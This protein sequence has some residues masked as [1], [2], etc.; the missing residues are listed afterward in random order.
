MP[1]TRVFTGLMEEATALVEEAVNKLLE[2]QG[3]KK[4][5]MKGRWGVNAA[6][7]NC[8]KGGRECVGWH[9][10]QLTY[11][12]PM[13]VIASLSLGCAREF[14]VRRV[15]G[16]EGWEG[17]EKVGG[18]GGSGKKDGREEVDEGVYSLYL[19]HNSLLI[20]HAGMQESWKHRSPPLPF[21]S[22]SPANLRS[23]HP[24]TSLSLHP[25]AGNVRINITYRC[26]RESLRPEFTPRCRCGEPTIL[27]CRFK[28]ERE[29]K[30]LWC[31]NRGYRVGEKGCGFGEGGRFDEFGEPVWG[32]MEK[33]GEEG[34]GGEEG[35]PVEGGG[36]REEVEVAG[37][38]DEDVAELFRDS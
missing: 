8:Y 38:E 30:Y 22:R 19:P 13:A 27:R 14:R 10:D 16:S 32:S 35:V 18:E 29:G 25:V 24:A 12:G 15:C 34:S 3:W 7:V 17:G 20:M 11:L 5:M 1:E 31:C 2:K 37:E 28:G 33:G 21:L 6:L 9:S 23:I 4:G 36:C 26:F